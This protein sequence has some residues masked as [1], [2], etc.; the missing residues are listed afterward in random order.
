MKK[1]DENYIVDILALTPMQEG[2]LFHYLKDPDSEFYFEQL[3]LDISGVI[4]PGLFEKAWDFV[5]ETNTILRTVF[6]WEKIKNPY[7]VIL[8]K[9][10]LQWTFYDISGLM[11][12]EKSQ[13]ME[14]IKSTDRQKRFDLL[15]VPF[16]VTLCKRES[17]R[18]LMI[19]SFHHILLDGWSSGI[20]LKEFLK[21]Y[22]ALEAGTTLA[23]LHKTPFKEFIKWVHNNNPEEEAKTW[24]NYLEGVEP[25]ELSIK[26]GRAV[27]EPSASG[28][29]QVCLD[30]GLKNRIEQFA[31]R[32]RLTLAALF[33]SAWGILLQRYNNTDDVI[34]GTTVS[35][36]PSK[37]EGSAEMTGLFINTIPL[38][39]RFLPTEHSI[40]F[41]RRIQDSLLDR[42]PYELSSLPKIKEFC[43]IKS[44]ETLFD[45]IV[46]LENY[47]I[48][49]AL[50]EGTND[51]NNKNKLAVLSYS[52][53]ETTHYDLSLGITLFNEIECHFQYQNE[54]LEDEAVQQLAGYFV[55]IVKSFMEKPFDRITEIE[56][57]SEE[58]KKCLLM[59]FNDTTAEYP[60]DKT[61]HRLFEEQAAKTPDLIAVV[62]Q[63]AFLKNRPLDPQKTF[64]YLTY[65]QLNEQ[66]HCLAGSLIE[67]GVLPDDIVGI[68]MERSLEMVT[69]IFAI[70]KA[71]GAYMPIDPEYPQ[72]RIQYMLED[73]NAKILLGIE[74]CRK[75][76][77]NNCQLLIVNCKL[78]KGRP[79][80][81][82]HHSNHLAYIIYTSGSTG[83]P[84]GVM[85]PY[86][87]VVNR[88]NWAMTKYHLNREDVVMQKTSYVFDVSVC[89][90]FRWIMPGARL[91]LLPPWAEKEPRTILSFI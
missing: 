16:R 39:I 61:I 77:I 12:G 72:E 45:S 90:L 46:V 29:T 78:L 14:D 73:S 5:I 65:R 13:R 59:D 52:M 31:T 19:V 69:G 21:A 28:S 30:A 32:N 17:E 36:R 8:K 62:G 35:G 25:V 85:V 3:S 54:M 71:G 68:M 79:R 91:F 37:L 84:K 9:H 76:I 23:P 49:A 15:E 18:H 4:N 1:L 51:V 26:Q 7:Q 33:Y 42:E 6:R 83:K 63:G 53:I 57:L 43:R 67:K 40:D 27:K 81:G 50:Y 88:M 66:S 55:S 34:F 87:A 86:R 11:P 20:V 82:L 60:V 75:E 70:L 38:R 44:D 47:P 24:Q 89:E 10:P 64:Y 80:R 74:E 48:D 2:M 22:S 58:E 41:L 56:I